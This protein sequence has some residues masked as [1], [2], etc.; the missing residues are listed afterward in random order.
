V[1]SKSHEYSIGRKKRK[2][3]ERLRVSRVSEPQGKNQSQVEKVQEWK[4]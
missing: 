3:I 4:E 2:Y 1:W